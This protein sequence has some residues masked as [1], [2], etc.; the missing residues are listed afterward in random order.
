MRFFNFKLHEEQ[1]EKLK[2]MLDWMFPLSVDITIKE[3]TIFTIVHEDTKSTAKNYSYYNALELLVFIFPSKLGMDFVTI[4]P[5]RPNSLFQIVSERF[6]MMKN[7]PEEAVENPN[8]DQQRYYELG[9][10]Y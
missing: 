3:G 10:G 7:I 9:C 2:E 4:D 6:D 8:D 5:E 1:I